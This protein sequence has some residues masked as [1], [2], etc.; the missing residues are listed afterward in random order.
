MRY[1]E[2]LH[3]LPKVELHCHLIGSMRPETAADL[4]R[5]HGVQLPHDAHYL[6]EHVN[7]RQPDDPR[8]A[9]TRISMD[10][11][12]IPPLP[13]PSF[14]LFQVADWVAP[15]LRD[16]GD[17]ARVVY[18]SMVDAA[19]SSN[20]CYREIA[21]EP[22]TFFNAGI[23]YQTIVDGLVEGVRAA[24]RDAGIVG[25]LI[26]GIDRGEPPAASV[27]VV[28]QMLA[29]PRDEVV[30]IGLQAFE[31]AGPPELFAEAYALAGRGGLRRT[32]HASEHDPSSRNVLTCLDLLGCDRIDHGYFVL[33]DDD[34]VKRCRDEGIV[35]CCIGTTSRRTWIPWRRRSIKAMVD[36]G[37]RV[38]IASDDPAMFPTTVSEQYAILATELG[39]GPETMRQI[40]Q[41]GI[42]AAWTDD[43]LKQRLRDDLTREYDALLPQLDVDANA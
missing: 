3:R 36:A 16:Q 35:F 42:D 12:D 19:R 23:S 15:V 37:L 4:A 5:K 13:D 10:A 22:T 8:Y 1:D 27:E 39:F 9:Q 20:V 28:E 2:F 14:S 41:N 29:H 25:R 32:A 31:L 7:S 18:E 30:G 38:S 6:Y 40:A 26:G 21:F 33:E 17:F 43:A 11:G 34:A 24:E